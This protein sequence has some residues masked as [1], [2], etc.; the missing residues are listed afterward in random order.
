[1]DR[2]TAAISEF[3]RCAG[4]VNTQ[5]GTMYKGD[6]DRFAKTMNDARDPSEGCHR[7]LLAHITEHGC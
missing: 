2:Y 4:I 5:I 1:M 3:S 6:Y 7:A